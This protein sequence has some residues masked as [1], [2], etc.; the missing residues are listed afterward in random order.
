MSKQSSATLPHVDGRRSKKSAKAATIITV[1]VYKLKDSRFWQANVRF[2]KWRK[3]ISTRTTIDKSAH[4][5][6]ELAFRHFSRLA[7]KGSL[8]V[9]PPRE[10]E[11]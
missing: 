3:R 7:K 9:P 2:G 6:A 5:F 4:E 1:E 11:P 10:V 8:P